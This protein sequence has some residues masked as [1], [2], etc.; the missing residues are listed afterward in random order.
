MFF[1]CCQDYFTNMATSPFPITG[2][3]QLNRWAGRTFY[4]AI[5]VIKR[6]LGFRGPFEGPLNSFSFTTRIGLWEFYPDPL[7][8]EF[9]QAIDGMIPNVSTCSSTRYLITTVQCWILVMRPLL[10]DCYLFLWIEVLRYY[11]IINS[12]FYQFSR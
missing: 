11:Y 7:L 2:E 4:R 10:K 12:G 5:P 9:Y 6:G 1:A 3:R 8:R